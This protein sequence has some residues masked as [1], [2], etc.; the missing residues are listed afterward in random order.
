[1]F[2][3]FH[4]ANLVP[5]YVF[6][7]TQ[8]VKIKEVSKI[9]ADETSIKGASIC[10]RVLHGDIDSHDKATNIIGTAK[11]AIINRTVRFLF[12]Q[13]RKNSRILKPTNKQE[14]AR[15]GNG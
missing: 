1:M 4:Y 12:A 6:I 7:F 8:I 13:I 5:C 14:I 11:A 9:K 10:N 3:W 2:L 15:I